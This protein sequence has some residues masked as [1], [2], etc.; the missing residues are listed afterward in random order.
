MT[1]NLKLLPRAEFEISNAALW[2]KFKG[3]KLEV[4]F[5]NDLQ[6]IL[7]RIAQNP[8]QF[9]LNIRKFRQANFTKFPFIVIYK[10]L[11]DNF[12]LIF[13]IFNTHQNPSKKP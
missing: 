11:D 4:K 9:Q 3:E 5:L 12:I 1:F 13:S 8:F 7:N 2:Y 6:E 10:V